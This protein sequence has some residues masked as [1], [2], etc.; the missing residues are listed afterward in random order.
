V[1][2][3][4]AKSLALKLWVAAAAAAHYIVAGRVAV[5]YVLLMSHLGVAILRREAVEPEVV[6]RGRRRQRTGRGEKEGSGQEKRESETVR[7]RK[8][9][10]VKAKR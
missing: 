10:G 9:E 8:R 7:D 3:A 1:L 4:S 5:A 2:R 6:T